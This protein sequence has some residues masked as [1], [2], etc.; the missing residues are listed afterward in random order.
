MIRTTVR[1]EEELFK[2]ARKRAIDERM[3]FADIVNEALSLYLGKSKKTD[4]K[5][6]TSSEFLRRLAAYKLKG[7]PKDLAKEHDKYTWE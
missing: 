7:G 1:L 2:D 6:F 3:A 4:A 5:K